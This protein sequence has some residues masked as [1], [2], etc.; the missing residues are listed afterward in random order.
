M[1]NKQNAKYAF[2]YLLSL[3]ALI[4]TAQAVGM[5]SFHIINQTVADVLNSYSG[6]D[7]QLKFAISALF[8]AAPIFFAISALI[9]KGLRGGELDKDSAIR[10]WLTYFILFVSSL[11]VLGVFISAINAFLD[12]ELT[13]RFALKALTIFV[14][15]AVVFSYYFYDIKRENPEQ[16]DT[17]VK[18]YFWA[19]LAL[20]LAAFIAAWFF[21]ESP[22]TAR[23]RR[24]DQSLVNN[25]SNL[26]VAV[27]S[28][29]ERHKKLPDTL[30]I[31]ASD[32]NV[33]LDSESL[34]DPETKS[35]IV[36]QLVGAQDFDLCATFRLDSAEDGS[37]QMKVSYPGDKSHRAGYQ[38]LRGNL[39]VLP[40]AS[41]KQL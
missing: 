11:V 16:K 26:E 12:G 20:V 37:G 23:A 29:Y 39:Y 14:I 30:E 19:S 9:L 1:P 8:I 24:L 36:Y 31:L 13:S 34:F 5:I 27:N 22:A 15:A 33:Y 28:Y 17:V 21:V 40:E 2:Y 18:I 35:P 41:L 32:A 3:V 38:C 7:G 4:F 6:N 10:R 25:I